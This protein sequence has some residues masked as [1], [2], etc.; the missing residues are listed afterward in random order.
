M[1]PNAA[2]VGHHLR[3]IC[4]SC[5]TQRA[6]WVALRVCFGALHDS[7]VTSHIF[8]FSLR[9]VCVMSN[10]FQL[11]L[12][13]CNNPYVAYVFYALSLLGFTDVIC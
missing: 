2:Q 8:W 5:V 10:I 3:A 7:Q 9:A 13:A 12:H 6:F 4:A 1:A 11:C